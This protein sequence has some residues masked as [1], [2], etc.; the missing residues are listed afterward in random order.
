M[1]ATSSSWWAHTSGQCACV[2]AKPFQ[3]CPTHCNPVDCS[4][5]VSS[6]QGFSRQ[7]NCS[8]LSRL[9]P[10]DLPFPGTEPISRMSSALAGRF[11]T[12]ST[13]RQKSHQMATSSQFGGSQ[14][15]WELPI[16]R[17]GCPCRRLHPLE[18]RHPFSTWILC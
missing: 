15:G 16:H 4:P 9:P 6:V 12:T 18:N 13:T 14:P 10:E 8:G 5:P 7:G 2:H 3:S 17:T 1:R 11:F